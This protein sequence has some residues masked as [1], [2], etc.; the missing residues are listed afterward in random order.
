MPGL[1]EVFVAY[2]AK[3]HRKKC[4]CGSDEELNFYELLS[5]HNVNAAG[6]EESQFCD[7]R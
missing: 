3:K 1:I 6:V 5:N 7:Y 2:W 4:S